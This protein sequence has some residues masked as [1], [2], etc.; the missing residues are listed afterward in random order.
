LKSRRKSWRM[1]QFRFRLERFLELK[2]YRER[3]REL[4]LARV[5][6]Q[7]LMLKKR[8][9][10]ILAEVDLSRGRTFLVDGL[11]DVEAMARGEMYIRR[12][13][14]EKERTEAALAQKTVELEEARARYLEAA[15]ERKVLDKLKERTRAEYYQ[16]CKDEEFKVIDDMNTAAR[17]RQH[18]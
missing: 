8:I 3:E 13:I 12:L 9:S 5:L 4:A 2:R 11:I 16:K 14:R 6:G 15:K 7:V 10:E 17:L 18:W 1:R